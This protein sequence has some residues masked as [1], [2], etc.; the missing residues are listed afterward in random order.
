MPLTFIITITMMM[1]ICGMKV[2]ASILLTAISS[3]WAL[4]LECSN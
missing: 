4:K 1:I 2:Q 3:P